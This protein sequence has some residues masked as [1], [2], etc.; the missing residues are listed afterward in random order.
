MSDQDWRVRT[1][2][3]RTLVRL[4]KSST[5]TDRVA[6]IRIIERVNLDL[7]V[8]GALAWEGPVCKPGSHIDEFRLVPG[9]VL[10]CTQ[11]EPVLP[12]HKGHKG[13]WRQLW[14]LWQW[15]PTRGMWRELGRAADM[16]LDAAPEL[17]Q[18]A[19][20]AMKQDAWR[21]R[22]SAE[23]AADRLYRLFDSECHQLAA[24]VRPE[25]LAILHQLVV[26]RM[27]H[28][29]HLIRKPSGR[30]GSVEWPISINA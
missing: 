27:V 8:Y 12:G 28:E 5:R 29:E 3:G 26:T 9:I 6:N 4:P 22:E 18:L 2:D 10:E 17:R 24:E 21:D 7:R 23:A 11:A 15:I 1:P 30:A 16:P 14:I 20:R 25:V 19:R 13:R